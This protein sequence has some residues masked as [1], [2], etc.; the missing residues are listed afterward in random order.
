MAGLLDAGLGLM[1][2][3][4]VAPGP[5]RATTELGREYGQTAA[6]EAE[7]VGYARGAHLW[8]DLEEVDAATPVASVIGFC[9][10]WYDAVRQAGFR[11]GVYVGYGAR[12]SAD[13]LYLKL[14]FDSYWSAYNLDRPDYPSVRGVM[15]RQ[16]AVGIHDRVNGCPIEFDVNVI[17]ADALGGTPTLLLPATIVV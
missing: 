12:L 6:S 17:N 13:Q 7:R 1:L 14:R 9:N 16:S 10:A 4:H 8:C 5:W 11:P 3:Q 15:M 2:V